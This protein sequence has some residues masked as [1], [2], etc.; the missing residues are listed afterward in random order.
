ME[1]TMINVA[2]I[3]SRPM[4]YGTRR[5][6]AGDDFM[7]DGKHAKILQISNLASLA[8]HVQFSPQKKAERQI[9]GSA[10]LIPSQQDEILSLRGEYEA[11]THKTPDLRWGAKRLREEIAAHNSNP[12]EL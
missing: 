12:L 8:A 7:A 5:L 10:E 4:K 6:R 3:A 9:E 1:M 11:Q 2:M